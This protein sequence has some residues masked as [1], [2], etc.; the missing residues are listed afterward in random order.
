MRFNK[1]ILQ[2]QEIVEEACRQ[3]T[4]I[5]GYEI[6]T[7]HIVKVVRYAKNLAR[8]RGADEEIVELAALLHDY[9]SITRGISAIAQHHILSAQDAEGIL[10]ELGY[11]ADRIRRVKECI[12]THRGSVLQKRS[13]VEAQCVADADALAHFEG[14]PSLFRYAYLAAGMN[15]E[16]AIEWIRSKLERSWRKLSPEVKELGREKY[17]ACLLLLG[18]RSNGG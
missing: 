7:H 4:N 6:W 10:S 13:S 16:E 12:L 15:V 2:V 11:P 9:A 3:P 18:K 1:I 14:L 8:R 5:F 17:E